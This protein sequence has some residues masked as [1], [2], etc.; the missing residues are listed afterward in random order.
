MLYPD[1]FQD[2]YIHSHRCVLGI[3]TLNTISGPWNSC[4]YLV[5]GVVYVCVHAYGHTCVCVIDRCN[6]LDL[7]NLKRE[8]YTF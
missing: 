2:N 5:C 1:I 3:G 7:I 8:G 6:C 4:I